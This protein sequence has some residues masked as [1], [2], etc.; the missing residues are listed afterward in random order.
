MEKMGAD[1]TAAGTNCVMGAAAIR[2]G[3]QSLQPI[4]VRAKAFEKEM[5]TPE[6][7]QWF[8]DHYMPRL[9][10]AMGGLMQIA[11]TCASDKDFNAAMQEMGSSLDN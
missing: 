6:A 7:E 2:N 4:A 3:T 9:M 10:T 5:E 11:Q 1:V 8:K